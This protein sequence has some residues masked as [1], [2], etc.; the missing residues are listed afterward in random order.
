M[1]RK[2]TWREKLEAAKTPKTIILPRSY[3]GVEEGGKL[4]IATPKVVRDYMRR[5]PKGKTRDMV[6][7]RSDLAKRYKADATCPTS[8][9]IFVRIAAEAAL[10]ELAELK[11]KPEDITPFW[12]L[13]DPEAPIAKRLSCGP[14]FIAKMRKAESH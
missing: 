10:E 1:G 12:R 4:L 5:I 11:R 7:L 13:I 8:S 2:K 9:A 6:R 14:K 3:A